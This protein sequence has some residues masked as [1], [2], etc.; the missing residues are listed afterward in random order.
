MIN[1]DQKTI[2]KHLKTSICSCFVLCGFSTNLGVPNP[3]GR[4]IGDQLLPSFLFCRVLRSF[5]PNESMKNDHTQRLMEIDHR[6]S[7]EIRDHK[8]SRL[9]PFLSIGVWAP[10]VQAWKTGDH[11]GEP[12]KLLCNLNYNVDKCIKNPIASSPSGLGTPIF[13]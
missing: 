6:K 13:W 2:K 7:M 9:N 4:R 1:K 11:L 3:G 8:T 5:H 12:R 10:H